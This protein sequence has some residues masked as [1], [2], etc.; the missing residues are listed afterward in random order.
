MSKARRVSFAV[1]AI[2][3]WFCLYAASQTPRQRAAPDKQNAPRIEIA[4]VLFRYSPELSINVVR[5]RGSLLPTEGHGLPSFNDASSFEIAA[6][7]AQ[8]RM[9]TAQLSGLMNAWLLSSPSAQIKNVRITASGKQLLIQGTMRKGLHVPFQATGDVSVT[10]DNR[11]RIAVKEV[12]T[13]H[14]P[15]KGILDAFGLKMQD[16]IS[17]KGLK[18]MSVDGD[19][20]VIDPQ[21]AFPPPQIRARLADA[22]VEGQS[23]VIEFGQGKPVLTHAP[24][25]NFIALRGG[26]IQYGRE[27][28]FDADLE[29]IDSTPGDPFEFFLARYWCQMVASD[30]KLKPDQGVRLRVI[31]FGKLPKGACRK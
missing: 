10:N 16:L 28:M 11:I 22:R 4:N 23:L 27:Q 20:F 17:Q 15:V 14:L 31:D 8:V 26:I 18:G 21:T 30:I 7:A 12:R 6:D 24:A 9:S 29:M 2:A 13:A 1:L 19:S 3:G 25:P 5:L